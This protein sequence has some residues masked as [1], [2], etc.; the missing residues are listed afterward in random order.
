MLTLI[1]VFLKS[2]GQKFE[3][4]PLDKDGTKFSLSNFA[5]GNMK[6]TGPFVAEGFKQWRFHG[7]N[8]ED[9]SK[10]LEIT[11]KDAA[12]KK[13]I[14]ELSHDSTLSESERAV[15]KEYIATSNE[16]SQ[17]L[18]QEVRHNFMAVA[19]T[20]FTKCETIVRELMKYDNGEFDGKDSHE[21]AGP[22]MFRD[23]VSA[24]LPK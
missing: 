4:F 24:E 18:D 9:F 10:F 14:L 13:T 21:K 5:F 15:L 23:K 1:N 12:G 19:G 8:G 22:G 7:H 3:D 20:P 16:T 2:K 6:S 17:D 11:G